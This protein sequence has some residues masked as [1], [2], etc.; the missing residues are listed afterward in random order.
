[1][2]F[3]AKPLMMAWMVLMFSFGLPTNYGNNAFAAEADIALEE[4]LMGIES[5]LKRAR[6][7]IK[8]LKHDYLFAVKSNQIMRDEGLAE[9]DVDQ[10]E[11]E[12]KKKVEKMIEVAM[13]AMDD[14]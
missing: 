9:A 12:F 3:Y 14:V 11:R 10:I 5:R 6:L 1:M 8:K 13:Y 2:K 7:I 4:K